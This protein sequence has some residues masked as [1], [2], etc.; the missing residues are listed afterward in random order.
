MDI[1]AIDSNDRD[2]LVDVSGFVER[3]IP[4]KPEGREPAGP[5]LILVEKTDQQMS[6]SYLYDRSRFSARSIELIV[7]AMDSLLMDMIEN[8]A[9]LIRNLALP[10]G[11][12]KRLKLM[13][14]RA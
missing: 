4:T 7:E 14:T 3:I 12:R 13:D 11:L 8:P 9:R 10:M 6:L 5:L 1:V 2:S